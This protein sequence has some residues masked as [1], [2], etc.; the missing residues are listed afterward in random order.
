MLS[1]FLAKDHRSHKFSYG[2]R[3]K[4]PGTPKTVLI[5]GNIFPKLLKGF[6]FDPW[7]YVDFKAECDSM[8]GVDLWTILSTSK[9]IDWA[10]SLVWFLGLENSILVQLC[11]CDTVK[12]ALSFMK[13]NSRKTCGFLCPPLP[14]SANAQKIVSDESFC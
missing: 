5:E 8:Q 10:S 6:L 13:A 7:P 2:C 14:L 11:V 3:S 1:P 9:F 4:I 12:G